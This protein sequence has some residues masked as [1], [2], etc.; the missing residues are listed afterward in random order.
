MQAFKKESA[1]Q[2]EEQDLLKK[3]KDVSNARR[4]SSLFGG[5]GKAPDQKEKDGKNKNNSTSGH[6]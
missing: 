6:F 5:R 4:E 2:N 1:K 3:L